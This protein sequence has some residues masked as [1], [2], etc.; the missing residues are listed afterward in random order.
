MLCCDVLCQ[1]VVNSANVVLLTVS[2]LCEQRLV[3]NFKR[4]LAAV[5]VRSAFEMVKGDV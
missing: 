5:F 3:R 1:K 4:I 2:S